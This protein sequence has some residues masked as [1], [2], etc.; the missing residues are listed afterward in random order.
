MIMKFK[1]IVLIGITPEGLGAGEWKRLV[2]LSNSK[3]E[4]LPK[5]TTSIPKEMTDADCL[6]VNMGGEVNPQ[7]I[8]ALPSLRY[9]GILATG[10]GKIN[11]VYAADRGVA[12]CNVAQY[13]TEDVAQ[14]TFALIHGQVSVITR[15]EVDRVGTRIA[16]KNLGV[17]GLGEIG[18]AVAR[19]A[20]GYNAKVSYWSFNRKKSKEND[21]LIYQ[22]DI[23]KL[24]AGSDF[25]SINIAHKVDSDKKYSAGTDKMF[26]ADLINA[27]KSGAVVV[28]TA[29]MEI[30]DL[31]ALVARLKKNDIT[32]I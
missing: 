9:I 4:L 17:V 3:P 1:K 7:M 10:Y 12:V 24:L 32:F 16:G 25:V 29:P 30:I 2:G 21:T 19:I 11:S 13:S 27:I 28:N 26:N 23:K 8:D 22:G 5:G 6:L 15:K 14:L 18:S 20:R 31:D